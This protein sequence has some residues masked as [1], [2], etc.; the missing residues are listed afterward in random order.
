MMRV[1][2]AILLVLASFSVV[3][4]AGTST[5]GHRAVV[6]EKGL[7]LM[8]DRSATGC[9]GGDQCVMRCSACYLFPSSEAPDAAPSLSADYTGA[10]TFAVFE[11]DRRPYRPPKAGGRRQ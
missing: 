6:A 7:S 3:P 11:L 8:Q 5:M 4:A 9:M 2:A 10:P 1:L